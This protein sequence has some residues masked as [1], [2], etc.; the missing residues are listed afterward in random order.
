MVEEG[1][2]PARSVRFQLL[3]P[4]PHRVLPARAPQERTRSTSRTESQTSE[5][6]KREAM[7]QGNDSVGGRERAP[8][9]ARRLHHHA[10][11]EWSEE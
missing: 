11:L 8:A 3:Q 1:T 7:G 5:G 4:P 9:F 2:Q 6:I 10:R